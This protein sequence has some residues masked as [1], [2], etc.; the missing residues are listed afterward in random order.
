MKVPYGTTLGALR[1]E[2]GNVLFSFLNGQNLYVLLDETTVVFRTERPLVEHAL[3]GEKYYAVSLDDSPYNKPELNPG[4]NPDKAGDPAHRWDL[5]RWRA[6]VRRPM[7]HLSFIWPA[8]VV[9]NEEGAAYLVFPLEFDTAR[10][11]PLADLMPNWTGDRPLDAHG[12]DVAAQRAL[13]EAVARS[14]VAAWRQLHAVG[15]LYLGFDVNNMYYDPDTGAVKF[16]FSLSTVEYDA[17]AIRVDAVGSVP[18]AVPSYERI[19]V[20]LDY[21]DPPT[22]ASI[23]NALKGAGRARG[24]PY[25]DLFALHAMVFRLLVG[26]LPFYGRTVVYESNRTPE[27]HRRWLDVYQNNPV[28]I[29]DSQNASNRVGGEDGFATD[30]VYED[31]WAAVPKD[32]REELEGF[33]DSAKRTD[34]WDW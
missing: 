9:S 12:E 7:P 27:E 34:R 14:L 2:R 3:T 32:L 21:V 20:T 25:T 19:G 24:V 1:A 8:D 26:R 30:E 17:Q 4:S 11:R 15:Y 29:F 23:A 10:Y 6:V 22:Y 13:R 31:N 33:F 28:F 5:E 18:L 16:G